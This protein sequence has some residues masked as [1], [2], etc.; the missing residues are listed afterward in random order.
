MIRRFLTYY[1]PHI[2]LFTIDMLCALIV[3]GCDLVYPIIARN[4]IN[5]YVPQGNMRLLFIWCAV[6]L[7]LYLAKAAFNYVVQ[8]WGHIVGVRIQGDMR[9]DMFEH[10]Q[11]LPFAFFD[12]NKTGVIM[13]R[14]INDLF[15]ISELA[16][17]GPE[18]VFIS[19]VM[20]L[21]S[22]AVLASID[23]ALT[24][25]VFIAVPFVIWFA[26][27]TRKHM[28]D[29]FAATREQTAEINASVETA[30]AGV[31]V[32]RAYTGE[33]YE[34]SRFAQANSL[35][36]RA[37]AAAYRVMGWFYS[38]TGLLTD[39]LY[40]LVL[41]F[42]GVFFMR[43]RID[44]GD[45]AAYLLYIT[46]FLKPINKFITL[47]EQLQSGMT[48]FARFVEVMDEPIE[49]EDAS[50]LDA[51]TLCG[52]IRFDHVSFQYRS[53]DAADAQSHVITDLS[54][55][56]PVGRTLALVGPSG[57]GKTTLCNLIPRFYDVDFGGISID[58][59]D[60]RTLKRSALRRN[61]GIVAQDVFLFSGTIREN[62]AYGD[63]NATDEQ[64][65]EAAKRANIHEYILTLAQGY[66]TD[67][68]ERG[69]KLS[70]GQKQRIAIARVFLKNPAI[71]ILDEATSALDNHTEMLI[72][73]ALTDL[74][75]GRTCIVVAHRLSTIKNADEIVVLTKQGIAEQGSHAALMAAEG[76]YA[77]LYNYQF[78][79]EGES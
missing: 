38:G 62:I 60:I 33:A 19:A 74:A 2:R 77:A 24:L 41:L 49:Q 31:R 21:G 43:G 15:D 70:G 26:V 68:G 3:A 50:A 18:D 6:M 46:M 8:Y 16:H 52:E 34:A 17:H 12:E 7:G 76:M 40:L 57:G 67:V 53:S 63:L 51:G 61:I 59:L 55:T 56:I 47:F 79:V 75:K 14:M 27:H 39:L 13:S 20:L 28:R 29:A 78:R 45:F 71:L 25:I 44:A 72:Q 58:G 69:I 48:G 10:L 11:K 35:F 30:I 1:K 36:M 9:R 22:F 66:N 37:R 64:V 65:I 73:R 32:S 23:L 4:I 5:T 42:G 54:L